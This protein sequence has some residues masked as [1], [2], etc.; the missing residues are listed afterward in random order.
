MLPIYLCTSIHATLNFKKLT[1][2]ELIFRELTF[3]EVDILGVDI[4]G[5]DI[6]GVDILRLTPYSH[7]VH[8]SM[9]LYMYSPIIPSF[10]VYT[11]WCDTPSLPVD[12]P[13][14]S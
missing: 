7:T 2:W 10:F 5:V 4:S 1:F 12:P 6:L 8:S 14:H 11:L 3:W 9:F 13:M